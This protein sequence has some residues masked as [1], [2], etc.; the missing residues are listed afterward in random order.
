M[1]K[2]QTTAEAKAVSGKNPIPVGWIDT[3]KGDRADPLYRSR[4]VAKEVQ[5]HR[6]ESIFAPT[7]PVES[8]RIL[9]NIAAAHRNDDRPYKIMVTDIKRAHFY[10][11]ALRRVFIQ[12]PPEDPRSGDPSL[13]GELLQSM[14]GA[15]DAAANWE[16]AYSDTFS[17]MSVQKGVASPCHFLGCAGRLFGMVHGDDFITVAPEDE[18]NEL[19]RA[20][21][22]EYET[23][24]D[25]RRKTSYSYVC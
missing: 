19:K 10:A 15:Q 2:Y 14:Y 24:T 11:K 23:K 8:L 20:M 6:E 7:P 12:L 16:A 18:L 4:I 1:Y 5:R 25:R 3:N 13:C 17:R 22:V 9:L 21:A